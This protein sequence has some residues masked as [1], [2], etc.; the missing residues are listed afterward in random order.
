MPNFRYLR[1]G[2]MKI[3]C[4]FVSN[5]SSA[6]Y[7]IILNVDW[8]EFIHRIQ[9]EIWD[10]FNEEQIIQ[11]V[12]E[13]IQSYEK[14]LEEKN[15]GKLKRLAPYFDFMEFWEQDL[16]A[17]TELLEEIKNSGTVPLRNKE[18]T[19]KIFDF[20]GLTLE[21]DL[22]YIIVGGGT[23]MHNSY[24]DG[25]PRLIFLFEYPKDIVTA[26]IQKDS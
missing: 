22:S 25:P 6:S 11:K 13:R 18:L 9:G 17:A 12:G 16:I 23:S 7:Q 1:R 10:W 19:Q 15:S 2:E 20:Y 14:R 26:S 8:D 24:N 21:F 5:S 4:G 3:R